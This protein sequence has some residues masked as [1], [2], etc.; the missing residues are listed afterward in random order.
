[1]KDHEAQNYSNTKNRFIAVLRSAMK[2]DVEKKILLAVELFTNYKEIEED[3]RIVIKNMD[4]IDFFLEI[5]ADEREKII[6]I[7]ES[8]ENRRD[9]ML[10]L[11]QELKKRGFEKGIQEGIQKGR[12]EGHQA[13]I[14]KGLQKGRQE[15]ILEGKLET[16][17]ALLKEKMPVEKIAQITGL[18]LQ[19]IQKL[20]K[21]N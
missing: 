13:G 11:S 1:M 17:E 14:E 15:G 12:Q 3:I 2:R 19:D 7:M 21:D 16:A 8:T 9:M 5:K 6:K 4:A 20:V 18:S 10:T